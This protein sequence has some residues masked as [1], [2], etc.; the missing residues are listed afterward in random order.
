[1]MRAEI[2]LQ[3]TLESQLG[4]EDLAARLGYS[5]SQIRRRFRQCFGM[6]PGAYRDMLRLEQAARLLVHTPHGVR[7]I[8]QQSGY[9]N[10]SA[11]S[12]AFQRHYRCSPRDF[13]RRERQQLRRAAPAESAFRVALCRT[14]PRE[15]IVT[16]LYEPS[17]AIDD[18][19]RWQRRLDDSEALS[20]RLGG[21]SPIAILHDQP[22]A[23]DAPRTDLG[24]QIANGATTDV[25]LPLPFRLIELPA[26]R[27]ACITLGDISQLASA[28]LFLVGRALPEQDEHINGES[29]R[30]VGTP[31][32]LE[33]QLPLLEP[34]D[35]PR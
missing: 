29:A 1:M 33:L 26:R 8:A 12:R 6:S 21:A 10:H 9:R 28:M 24:V 35:A 5:S 4:I 27:C 16:R 11:F 2:W 3:E 30:L 31:A 22:L 23:S 18:P 7:Q 13:R 15:A 17:T 20:S 14:P 34:A 25:A 19:A 32:G